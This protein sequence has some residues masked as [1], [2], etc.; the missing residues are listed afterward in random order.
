MAQNRDGIG[1]RTRVVVTDAA[2]R[3]YSFDFEVGPGLD[4][5]EVRHGGE[6]VSPTRYEAFR[7]ETQAGGRVRFLSAGETDVPLVLTVGDVIELERS[8]EIRPVV[9]PGTQGFARSWMVNAFAVWV[10]RV[11]EEVVD[12]LEGHAEIHL[13]ADEVRT[14]LAGAVKD[15][16]AEN[17]RS[18]ALGDTD[19]AE[20][21]EDSVDLPR[22]SFDATTGTLT[23]VSH[24]GTST[25]FVLTASQHGRGGGG[26][27]TFGVGDA[28]QFLQ[29]ATDG[30]SVRFARVAAGLVAVDAS[31]FTGNL[32]TTDDDVQKA[33]AKVDA[34][35][36][37][38][39]LDTNAV[40]TA[41]DARVPAWARMTQRFTDEQQEVFGAFKGNAWQ[42]STTIQVATTFS[43]SATPANP[44]NFTFQA[45]VV[46]GPRY[47]NVYAL[48]EVPDGEVDSTARR[49]LRVGELA[50]VSLSDA[51]RVDAAAGKTY[52]TVLL[53]DVPASTNLYVETL[54]PFEMDPNRVAGLPSPWAQRGNTDPVPDDKLP[55][56]PHVES[57][58]EFT[59][60]SP[61][62]D[63]TSSAADKATSTIALSPAVDMDT[64]AY[65]H[66]EFHAHIE[67]DVS[68]V[69]GTDA[70]FGWEQGKS[71]QTTDDRTA[72]NSAIVF[73]EAL[74]GS[75]DL[76]GGIGAG[77]GG[78]DLMRRPVYSLSTLLGYWRVILARDS[79]GNVG[80]IG[81]YES[82]GGNTLN[83]RFASR[84]RLTWTPRAASL[85]PTGVRDFIVATSP[86]SNMD[87][88][89][90]T[91]SPVSPWVTIMQLPAIVARQ[92]GRIAITAHMYGI[93]QEAQ[94][95]GGD[96]IITEFNLRRYNPL[97]SPAEDELL[98][99]QV[100]NGPRNLPANLPNTTTTEFATKSQII[101]EEIEKKVLA[102][103]GDTFRVEVRIT[104]QKPNVARTLRFGHSSPHRNNLQMSPIGL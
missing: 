74:R 60:L 55:P 16:A 97:T 8:T 1:V 77:G 100:D 34:L 76:T 54:V 2:V 24:D 3:T 98:V 92:A 78:I 22:C 88:A 79:Q 41:I 15:F 56:I 85:S 47:T 37:G 51:H 17:G 49:R 84:V 72:Q 6:L 35:T 42:D 18:I 28:Q 31:G 66:G 83:Y 62:L 81:F 104:A 5:L 14:L 20:T 52:Y 71:N 9:S 53:A 58:T 26:L 91:S 61:G 29:V 99:E 94:S 43:T 4:G 95:G 82:A 38:G 59:L 33:L 68:L 30:L 65:Q 27:P 67:T 13:T 63:T 45:R 80:V 87:V 48:I 19:F 57:A 64:T 10:R 93:V 39:T 101:T 44:E 46:T 96:R 89:C 103:V 102:K 36:T 70:N 21:I 7:S 75:D 50:P 40:N 32:A 11:F 73:P 12:A 69:S 25:D 90:T 23:L 86:N